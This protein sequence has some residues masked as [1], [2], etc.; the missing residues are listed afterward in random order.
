M[1][2]TDRAFIFTFDV[3]IPDMVGTSIADNTDLFN[4]VIPPNNEIEVQFLRASVRAVNAANTTIELCKDD[5]TVLSEVKTSATGL[6][7]GVNAGTSTPTTF[8]IRVAP[9]S[10]T[11]YS[12]LK[13]RSNVLSNAGA[14]FTVMVGVSGLN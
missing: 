2:Y 3:R 6:V 4:I 5:N 14:I 8:P 9:Q 12:S 1:A 10:T 11:A 13:L 7:V